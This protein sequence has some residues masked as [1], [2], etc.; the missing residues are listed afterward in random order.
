MKIFPILIL[1]LIGN[2]NVFAQSRKLF[3][4][5]HKT[6]N[7]YFSEDIKNQFKSRSPYFFEDENYIVTTSCSGEYGGSIIFKNK[8]TQLEYACRAA[9]PVTVNKIDGKYIVSASLAHIMGS[10]A[11]IQIDNPDSM[12]TFVAPWL[13]NGLLLSGE[14][15]SRSTKGTKRLVDTTEVLILASFPYEGQV[16]HITSD[17]QKT[18]L[19]KIENNR[20]VTLDPI[21]N[22]VLWT[23]G[24]AR[25]LTTDDHY[26][27]FFQD[28]DGLKGY[29][30]IAANKISI[31]RF[32]R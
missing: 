21:S 2:S 32:W 11:I 23:L 14:K 10:S 24:Q 12:A 9:C 28:N 7:T 13:R 6:V 31:I 18:Y 15:E 26:I 30:D 17:L 19:S 16:Y 5:V 22:E 25:I 20:F 1:L 29:L 27:A 8:K 3:T 4:I